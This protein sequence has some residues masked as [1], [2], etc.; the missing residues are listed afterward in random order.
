[1]LKIDRKTVNNFIQVTLIFS[2]VFYVNYNAAEVCTG[3]GTS[4]LL[5]FNLRISHHIL[6]FLA[7]FWPLSKTCPSA[8]ENSRRLFE[9]SRVQK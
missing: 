6:R 3:Y 7:K 5:M 8:R 4:T 9:F 2:K 1:M